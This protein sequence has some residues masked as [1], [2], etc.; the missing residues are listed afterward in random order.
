MTRHEDSLDFESAR[1]LRDVVPGATVMVQKST[2]GRTRPGSVTVLSRALSSGGHG[3][4][5]TQAMVSPPRAGNG[6][7]ALV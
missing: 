1:G 5:A 2:V 7:L 6:R 3:V 4:A